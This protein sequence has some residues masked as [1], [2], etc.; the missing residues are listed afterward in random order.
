MLTKITY[1]LGLFYLKRMVLIFNFFLQIGLQLFSKACNGYFYRE[2]KVL[3]DTY[4]VL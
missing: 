3:Q 1:V 2:A 4:L